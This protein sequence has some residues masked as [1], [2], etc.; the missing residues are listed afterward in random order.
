MMAIL[1]LFN[2]RMV[3]LMKVWRQQKIHV[4]GQMQTFMGG[5]MYPWF[6]EVSWCALPLLGP[7]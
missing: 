2:G 1:M 4:T 5:I 6:Q 3:E 7:R